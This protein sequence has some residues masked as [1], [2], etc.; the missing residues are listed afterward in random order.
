MSI[1]L[2]NRRSVLLTRKPGAI[3]ANFDVD[4]AAYITAVEGPL[5]DNQTLETGVRAAINDFVVGCKNDGVWNAIKASC[6][7]AGART[8]SGA[9]IPLAGTVP[10]NNNFVSGDYDRKT[11]LVGNGSSKYLNSNR[12]N[13][14]DPQNSVH[15]SVWISSPPTA[16]TARIH[17]G[18]GVTDVGTTHIVRGSSG[19]FGSRNRN[20]NHSSAEFSAITGFA[21]HSRSAAA[22][23]VIRANAANNSATVTS[24]SPFN[25]NVFV[26]A[27]NPASF[28]SDA[29]LAFYSIGESLDLALLDARVTALITAFGVAIP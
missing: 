21:G 2:P 25:G 3:P 24:E 5:G 9:L 28:Y 18:A 10:T 16:G 20:Q 15:Q 11:G 26:F 8:L 1:F 27:T 4:A 14:A 29:R 23:Y 6:I 17:I 13:N 22:S 12:N 19:L 7:L